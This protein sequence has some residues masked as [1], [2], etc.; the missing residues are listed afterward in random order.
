MFFGLSIYGFDTAI[1]CEDESSECSADAAVGFEAGVGVVGVD[2]GD[3]GFDCSFGEGL[4]EGVD[5]V[6]EGVARIER[7]EGGFG[8]AG[9]VLGV[10]REDEGVEA[11]GDEEGQEEEGDRSEEG[12]GHWVSPE[13]WA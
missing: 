10:G 6:L 13:E 7:V 2:P 12:L 9:C 3:F 8:V 5:D 1:G 4:A 11:D